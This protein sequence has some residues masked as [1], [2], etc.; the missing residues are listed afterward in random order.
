LKISQPSKC[1]LGNQYLTIY[2]TGKINVNSWK[3]DGVDLHF[4]GSL[5]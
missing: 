4:N 1:E 5:R 3:I 2:Q